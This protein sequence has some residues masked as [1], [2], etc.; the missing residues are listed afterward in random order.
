M[1]IELGIAIKSKTQNKN[2][3]RYSVGKFNNRSLM[4][5]HPSIIRVDNLKKVFSAELLKF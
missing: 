4:L 1:F 5:H 3:K 2:L